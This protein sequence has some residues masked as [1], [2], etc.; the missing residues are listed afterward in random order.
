MT[1]DPF[2][3]ITD[4]ELVDEEELATVEEETVDGVP[5][6]EERRA[7]APAPPSH[8]PLDPPLRTGTALSPAATTAVQTAAA[9]ATGFVA[10]AATLALVRRRSARKQA[11]ASVRRRSPDGLPILGSRSFLIDIHLLD[12]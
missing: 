3:Q 7:L 4:A 1:E 6:L 10:G 8:G 12:K 2:A 5:V 11:R 9:A